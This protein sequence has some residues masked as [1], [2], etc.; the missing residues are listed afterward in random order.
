LTALAKHGASFQ[1]FNRDK[2]VIRNLQSMAIIGAFFL[3]VPVAAQNSS[4]EIE[5]A[6]KGMSWEAGRNPAWELA[7]AQRLVTMLAALKPQ[8]AGVVDAYVIVI[9]L[10]ADP[11]FGR[12]AVETA[13]VL[14][15]RYDAVGRTILLSAGSPTLP[16]GS[17]AHLSAALAAVAGKMNLKEDAL[18]LYTTS[19]GA[20]GI[21]L[22]YRDGT[23]GYGMIAP[24][25]LAG[26]LTD[27]R[28]E[29][30][31]VMVSACYSGQFVTALATPASAIV[32]AADD[33]RTSFGCAPGNDWTFFGDALINN[34]LRK[35]Q[36]L[37]A[38]TTAAIALINGW[39]VSRGLTSSKPRVFIGEEAKRWLALLEKR[40]P[41][42]T[43][44]KVGRPSAEETK[45]EGGQ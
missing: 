39:E 21:G 36:P 38:A 19:H 40:M 4:N 44:A 7:Q 15:R 37:E 12:E 9:G 24:Q 8:R 35:A 20:P 14:A 33:D 18:I 2:R 45:A 34:E 28:V 32:T 3:T 42:G 11:V 30:R 31:L 6:N 17:P 43:T 1:Q 29:R 26:L 25:R 16:N 41:V 10:D 23:S 13:K 22:A 5:G 27:L